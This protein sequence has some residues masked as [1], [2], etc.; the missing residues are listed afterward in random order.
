MAQ[1][2]N[3]G[4]KALVCVFLFGGNDGNNMIIPVTGANAT[5]YTKG[6]GTLAIAIRWLWAIQAKG[7]TRV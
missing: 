3:S 2:T 7:C 5:N 4:Y 1:S 6:R